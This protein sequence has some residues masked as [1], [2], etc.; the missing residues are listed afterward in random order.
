MMTFSVTD[1]VVKVNVD[2]Y[3]FHSLCAPAFLLWCW[4]VKVRLV[5]SAECKA[6]DDI[7]GR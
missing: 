6:Y 4:L 1:A 5:T 7:G 2:A 3:P